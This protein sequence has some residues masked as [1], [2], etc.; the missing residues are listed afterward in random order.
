MP[1]AAKT[2]SN[3]ALDYVDRGYFVSWWRMTNRNALSGRRPR[4][5]TMLRAMLGDP[6]ARRMFG[7]VDNVHPTSCDLH[8]HHHHRHAQPLQ[9]EMG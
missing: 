9:H 7:H 4:P 6:L 1:S 8:H 5:I 2:T 3:P